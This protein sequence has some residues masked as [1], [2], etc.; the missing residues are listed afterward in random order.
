MSER[1]YRIDVCPECKVKEEDASEKKLYQ[2][3]YC[4]R[5][6]CERHLGLRV[7]HVPNYSEVVKDPAWREIVDKI[8]K[9]TMDTQI[10]PIQ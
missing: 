7:V 2:C 5:W 9:E 6:F 4:E 10:L 8:E 1:E 3:Q